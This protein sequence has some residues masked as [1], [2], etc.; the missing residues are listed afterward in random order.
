VRKTHSDHRGAL[1]ERRFSSLKKLKSYLHLTTEQTRPNGIA[2]LC[3]ARDG[4]VD[5]DQ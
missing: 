2:A 5:F 3:I 4:K 1:N